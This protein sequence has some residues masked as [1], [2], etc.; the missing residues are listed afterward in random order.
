[1]IY[2]AN[3]G[4]IPEVHE[5]D[6]VAQWLLERREKSGRR[7]REGKGSPGK[8]I[9]RE[10]QLKRAEQRHQRVLEGLERLELWLCDLVHN[11]LAGLEA[12]G[13]RVWEEQARRLV[14]AQ[15]PGLASWIRRLADIPGAS[16]Q[17][18]ESLLGEMGRIMLLIR[19]YRNIDRIEPELA[20]D[21]R[22]IIGWT[23]GQD[24]LQT[25]GERV[26]DEW[27]ILGHWIQ[28][29]LHIRT[30]RTWCTGRSTRRVALV[31]DFSV[32]GQPFE[33]VLLPGTAQMG[34]MVYYPGK[35]RQR[36]AFMN[37]AETC[38][39]LR[40]SLDG[41]SSI[42]ELLEHICLEI[43]RQPWLMGFGCV[44]KNVCIT[45]DNGAWYA[46]DRL[47]RALPMLGDNHWQTLALTGGKPL[48]LA[49]EWTGKALRPLGCLVEGT[50]R[51]L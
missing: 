49:G 36:A 26:E 21:V 10:A 35:G 37:R 13:P 11:G 27:A 5:P 31:L 24:E 41:F 15:A 22:Q 44:L 32:A 16:N 3:P 45:R 28:D 50:Y 29:G 42:D 25:I 4:D 17:W 30:R 14:D 38:S 47:G 1:L 9:N 2:S 18:P 40:G 43:S 6:W 34:N 46:R 51:L 20:A 8:P 7:S 19:A 48:D 39:P 33:Q 23:V 12:K